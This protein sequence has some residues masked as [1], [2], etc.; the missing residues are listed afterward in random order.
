MP[1]RITYLLSLLGAIL[2]S[3]CVSSVRFSSDDV[4]QEFAPNQ[5]FEAPYDATESTTTGRSELIRGIASY[6]ADKFHGRKTASGAIYNRNELSA[7]HRTL[8]FGS[9]VRVV[10]TKN[11]KEVIVIIND[12]GPMSSKRVIDLS[13]AAAEEL[14][15]I[16]DGI[17]EV[18][19]YILD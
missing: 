9:R 7:A 3:A 14:D 6:Y 5:P 16:R 11:G 1:E 2:L 18:E 19:L 4:S 12:R 15:M 17:V 10:N 8:P 13:R